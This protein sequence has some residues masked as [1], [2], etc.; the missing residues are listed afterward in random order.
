MQAQ[1]LV[2]TSAGKNSKHVNYWL[3]EPEKRDFDLWIV[4][5]P[6]G[7]PPNGFAD[8]TDLFLQRKGSKCENLAYVYDNFRERLNKYDAFFIVDD[9]IEINTLAINKLF[10][11][12]ARWN[13]DLCQ[14]AF[15]LKSHISHPHNAWRPFSTL[16]FVSFVEINVLVFGRNAFHACAPIFKEAK[17]GWGAD[18]VFAKYASPNQNPRI[19]V[20]DEI[21]CHHPFRQ[22][23]MDSYIPRHLQIQD[24]EELMKKYSVDFPWRDLVSSYE[25]KKGYT[26]ESIQKLVI[27]F[28]D[29]LI[30]KWVRGEYVPCFKK[31]M[32]R[33]KNLTARGE[34]LSGSN[35]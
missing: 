32:T 23:E 16:R 22:S 10:E 6:E 5:Y 28:A 7:E 15:S 1:N 13:L 27:K 31:N 14:P 8:N 26:P 12:R 18:L 9:D 25:L 11:M 35:T 4:Y 19:A 20:I 17:T 30:W 3:S 24:G 34:K 21:I 2:F 29:K 33:F